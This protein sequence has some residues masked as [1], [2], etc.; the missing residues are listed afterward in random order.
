LLPSSED[1][2]KP[3]CSQPIEAELGTGAFGVRPDLT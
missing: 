3:A 1:L 2:F